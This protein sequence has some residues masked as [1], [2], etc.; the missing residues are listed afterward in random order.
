MHTLPLM[1]G[2]TPMPHMISAYEFRRRAREAMKVFMPVLLVAALIAML[3]SLLSTTVAALTGADPNVLM[4]D[5]SNRMTQVM[6]KHGLMDNTAVLER[7]ELDAALLESDMLAAMTHFQATAETFLREKGAIIFGMAA[8][9]MVLS[10]VLKMGMIDGLLHALRRQDCTA[11]IAL[12]RV[13]NLPKALGLTLLTALKVFAWMLPGLAICLLGS[14]LPL[15]ATALL[16]WLRP[17]AEITPAV[18]LLL[19]GASMLLTLGGMAAMLIPGVM[20]SYR[21]AM[22]VFF[23]ADN[24]DMG[25]RDCI[26]RSCEI[27]KRRKMELFSLEISFIG[28]HLLLDLAKT[29]LL[30]MLG[31]V[32]GATLGMFA[33]LFLTVYTNCAQAAF[34]QEYAVGPLPEP[35]PAADDMDDMF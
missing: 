12:S 28:W 26:R 17:G 33:G 18:A 20:A 3:P 16:D 6:E 11:A 9:V 24:P 35:E 4:E 2:W 23:M 10:P 13:R 34:Y 15:G 31:S 27:M 22:A 5:Y 19:S 7:P 25:I 1:K 29:T 32:V 8:L 21:Y 14:L 30:G